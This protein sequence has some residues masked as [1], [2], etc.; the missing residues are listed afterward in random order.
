LSEKSSRIEFVY[1]DLGN[2]LLSFDPGISCGNVA[3]R[4]GVTAESVKDAIYTSGLQDQ[5]EHGAISGDEFAAKVRAALGQSQEK[6]PTNELLEAVSNMFTLIDGMAELMEQVRLKQR[7]VG[8][9]SNTCHAHW[10]WICRQNYPLF[11]RPLDA[12]VLSYEVGVM[13]PNEKIYQ[14]A[15][16][17]AGVNPRQILF[18]DDRKENVEG[19]LKRGWHA[20]QCFGGPTAIEIVHRYLAM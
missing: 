1:F 19:A 17:L 18:V 16:Q 6:L 9:L 10:D 13:K 3:E 15:E 20:E 11:A 14:H 5:L 2:M 8:L 12:T 7:R 4:F